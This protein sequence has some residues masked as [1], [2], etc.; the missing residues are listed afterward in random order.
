MCKNALKSHSNNPCNSNM[1]SNTNKALNN[2]T[3]L[4]RTSQQAQQFFDKYG[5]LID[6]KP[7]SVD[8]YTYDENTN[9]LVKA[10]NSQHKNEINIDSNAS[11]S[12]NDILSHVDNIKV[13]DETYSPNRKDY[14]LIQDSETKEQIGRM[15]M[16]EKKNKIKNEFLGKLHMKYNVLDNL[17]PVNKYLMNTN[18]VDI[19]E[20][21]KDKKYLKSN[22]NS[23]ESVQKLGSKNN[24]SSKKISE[25]STN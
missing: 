14:K 24:T 8:G 3:P 23:D 11:P 22:F 7:L 12:L 5:N 20:K 13:S 25:M 2:S 10:H 15:I 19:E 6:L 18:I 17:N 4:S 9:Q 1:T 16:V 21:E